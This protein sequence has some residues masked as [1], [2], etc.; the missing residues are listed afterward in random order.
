[1]QPDKDAE[2]PLFGDQPPPA[3]SKVGEEAQPS[4]NVV[5]LPATKIMR[6]SNFSEEEANTLSSSLA[7]NENYSFAIVASIDIRESTKFMLHVEKFNDYARIISD[8]IAAL[9]NEAIIRGGFFDKFTGDGALVFWPAPRDLLFR[10]LDNVTNFAIAIQQAFISVTIP[11]LRT[12]AGC[13]PKGFGLAIGIDHGRCLFSELLPSPDLVIGEK[14]IGAWSDTITVLG[15]AVVGAVRMVTAAGPHEIIMNEGPGAFY[16]KV[17]QQY[18]NSQTPETV[19]R[20]LIET[21]DL[22]GQQFAYQLE[23]LRIENAVKSTFAV[24]IRTHG[25]GCSPP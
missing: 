11:N 3:S 4:Q 18:R 6:C 19:R 23:H 21:R 7:A 14:T 12:T 5:P 2:K 22:H 13:M 24:D 20:V 8:F 25:Q 17:W 15:R 1:M 16:L 10:Q 9:R